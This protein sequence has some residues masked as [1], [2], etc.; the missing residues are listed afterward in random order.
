M[1]YFH[2]LSSCQRYVEDRA[3]IVEVEAGSLAEKVQCFHSNLPSLQGW[4]SIIFSLYVCLQNGVEKGDV[5]DELC[6]EQ[7]LPS[8]RGK[9]YLAIM[10]IMFTEAFCMA[11]E[12]G[13]ADKL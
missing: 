1:P 10:N 7:V 13:A 4:I 3:L 5:L 11:V 6:G 9:V 12:T 8:S 2:S